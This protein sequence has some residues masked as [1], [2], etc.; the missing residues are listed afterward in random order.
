MAPGQNIYIAAL[1]ALIRGKK[2]WHLKLQMHLNRGEQNVIETRPHIFARILIE[3]ALEQ[4]HI[5]RVE[6]AT[7]LGI[8]HNTLTRK[9]QGLS[10]EE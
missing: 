9:I 4:T 3:K 2:R 5:R 6:A 8:S 1:P 7:Q 10:I